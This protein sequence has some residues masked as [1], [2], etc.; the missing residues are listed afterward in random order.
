MEYHADKKEFFIISKTIVSTEKEAQS[1]LLKL[2]QGSLSI[3]LKLLSVFYKEACSYI[4]IE[5]VHAVI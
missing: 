1:K 2:T 4:F 5:S 3:C